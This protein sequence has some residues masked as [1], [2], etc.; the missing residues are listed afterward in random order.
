MDENKN[1]KEYYDEYSDRMDVYRMALVSLITQGANEYNP[2]ITYE[3]T[4]DVLS[5]LYWG[6]KDGKCP[7][8]LLRPK[9]EA[10]FKEK[11]WFINEPYRSIVAITDKI[12]DAMIKLFKTL[13]KAV[14]LVI[15]GVNVA[16]DLLAGT[17]DGLKDGM[18][19]SAWLLKNLPYILTGGVVVF[20]GVQ[21]YGKRKNGKFYGENAVR[22]V[23]KAKTGLGAAN[24]RL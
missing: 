19:L 14:E 16:I 6:M 20:A 12:Y 3:F 21:I 18:K 23:V 5:H 22:G 13:A 15:D 10:K 1:A 24:R 7:K 2:E 9:N 17:I 8:S 4:N 11:N